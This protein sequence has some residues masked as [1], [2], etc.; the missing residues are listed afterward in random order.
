MFIDS[1]S[2]TVSSGKGGPGCASFRR[3]KHVPLGGPDGGDGGNGG[4][5]YFIVDNN[6]HT[7]ANYKGKRVL[8]AANGVPG[9]P[10][11]M[12]GKKGENLE[13]IVPP[14]TAV[15]DNDSGELLLD[16]TTEGQKELFLL[17]GKGGLGN[18]H[19]KTSVNQAP[20]KAQPGLSGETKNI[21]LELKLI[22]DVGLVGFPNVGK[23]TLI[24]AVSN[25][26]PQ[27]ANYEFTTLTPK[28]GLVEV[29]QFNG[30][31][32]ADIPGIIEG[33]SDGKGLGI[34]FLKHIERTK[35]L[36]YMIDLANYRSL[37]EQF[38]TLRSEVEKFSPLLA[39]RSFAIA[40]TRA[41]VAEDIDEKVQNF[42]S[43]FGFEIKQSGYKIDTSLPY[44]VM[45]ISSVSGENLKELK[46]AL[47][48]ILKDDTTA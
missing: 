8:K 9:L 19:F 27:I 45:P 48:E 14:G 30:F 10:R 1:V 11:N 40:L 41:D 42:I 44:F 2:F 38:E 12:T 17:G 5:V 39:K 23:S 3:E 34:K 4:D 26:K 21:R 6:T 37:E 24:S 47:L 13:L 32:M 18:I 33:A 15:Y 29:D 7:L 22:A 46:F 28:L 20:S 35:V 31:V 36:L 43:K 25:A 16:L